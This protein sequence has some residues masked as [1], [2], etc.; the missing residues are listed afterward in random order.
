MS[1]LNSPIECHRGA[2]LLDQD[3]HTLTLGE[4]MIYLADSSVDFRYGPF[5]KPLLY[6]LLD[7]ALFL[8]LQDGTIYS[9]RGKV[10]VCAAPSIPPHHFLFFCTE[11]NDP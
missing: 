5:S 2:S 11:A 4:A 1:R 10:E 7:E 3:F 6:M 8:R 9:S